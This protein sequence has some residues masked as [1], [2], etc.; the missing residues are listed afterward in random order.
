MVGV[1]FTMTPPCEGSE[2]ES[3]PARSGSKLAQ[4]THRATHAPLGVTLLA[5]AAILVARKP[6]LFRHPQFWAEDGWFYWWGRL[7]GL[8]TLTA[9]YAGY[10]HTVPRLVARFAA[11]ADPLWAPAIFVAAAFGFTLYV[12]ART[13]SS[14]CPLPRHLGC[15]LA[16]VLVPDAFEVLLNLVN[17][18]WVLACGLLLLLVSADARRWWQHAHDCT[19]AV[20]FGLT[21]PFS[22]MLTPLFVWRAWMRRSRSSVVLAVLIGACGAV[23]LWEV[24]R[25]TTVDP[26]GTIAPGALLAVPGMRIAASL[27]AG[28]LVPLDYPRLVEN[29]LGLGALAA[30]A[31]LATR[32]DRARPERLWLAAAFALLLASSLY[33]VRFGLPDLCHAGFGSRYFFPL[34]LIVAWLVLVAATD[35]RRWPAR[36]AALVG[37]WSLAINFPRLHEPALIDFHWPD[38]AVKLRAGEAVAV[39]INPGPPWVIPF[40]AKKS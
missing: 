6:D 33:R 2:R 25:D 15:A 39:P 7:Y 3:P 35:G 11:L 40:P 13:Q 24:L 36:G 37:L 32:G 12:A 20:L 10:L 16:V 9:P 5:C 17:L 27:L 28:C 34:Q 26:S 14:R 38:Y 31:L 4:L 1:I 23:Q 18:Q 19:V 22:I 29:T 21:G 30:V 8:S